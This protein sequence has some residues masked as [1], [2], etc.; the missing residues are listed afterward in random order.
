MY[1]QKYDP[2]QAESEDVVSSK[3]RKSNASGTFNEEIEWSSNSIINLFAG[4]TKIFFII[5]NFI[6]LNPHVWNAGNIDL[7]D[8][9]VR[10]I[11]DQQKEQLW[12]LKNA[13]RAKALPSSTKW[14]N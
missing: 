10:Y 11:L 9:Q 14:W 8:L 12:L 3:N 4:F 1:E 7:S 13:C 5:C 6:K 2:K